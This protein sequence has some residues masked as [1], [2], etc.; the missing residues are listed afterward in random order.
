MKNSVLAGISGATATAF[1]LIVALGVA[2]FSGHIAVVKTGTI[3]VDR[4]S[5]LTGSKTAVCNVK[6][7]LTAQGEQTIVTGTQ[8]SGYSGTSAIAVINKNEGD[9]IRTTSLQAM[10]QHSYY[11]SHVL[12]SQVDKKN[13][14]AWQCINAFHVM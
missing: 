2:F 9:R 8:A 5:G 12:E 3:A 10:S 4:E 13:D 11:A 7:Y 14:L 6:S 1:V